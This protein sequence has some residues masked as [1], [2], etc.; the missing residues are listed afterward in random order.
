MNIPIKPQDAPWT[1]DQWKAI[2]ARG[3]DILVA[4][5][6]GS[7]KT[8][9]LVERIIQKILDEKD[10][11]NVNELLVA[12]FTNASAAEMRQRI[13][14]ALEKE[15]A[16]NPSSRHLRKQLNLLN[17]AQISTLHSFCLNVVKKYYYAIDI[18]P[19]FRIADETEALLLRDETLEELLEEEYGKENNEDF[20]RVVDIFTRDRSDS[21][22]EDLIS[23][24]YNFSRSHPEPEVWLDDLVEMYDATKVEKVDD[25]AFIGPLLYDIQ[26]KLEEAKRLFSEALEMTRLPGGPY[27]RAENFLQDIALVDQLLKAKD[28]SFQALYEAFQS[29]SFSTAKQAKGEDVDKEL[30]EQSLKLRNAGKKIIQD[31]KDE[32]FSRKP[33][34]FLKDLLE[35]KKPVETL[36]R[37][38]KTFSERFSRVKKEKGLI[39]F[40]DLEHYALEILSKKDPVTNK[41][42]PTDIA[43]TYRRQFKEVFID[44]YQ[45]TNMVQE[46]ILQ[47]VKKPGEATGNLFMVGDVKQSIYRFRLAE[48]NLFIGK[49]A[50]FTKDGHNTGLR[51]DLSQ[52]F[53]SRKEVLD[54][55]NFIFKQLMATRVGEIEYDEEAELKKGA[56]YPEEEAYPAE[57]VVLYKEQ[58]EGEEGTFSESDPEEEEDLFSKEEL[59]LSALE[60]RYIASKIRELID[61]KKQVYNPKTKAYHDIQYKDIVILLRSFT[62]ADQLMEEL[63]AKD[64]PAYANLSTGYFEATEVSIM[65]ALLNIIDNPYQD[66]PLAAV[67]RSP[68]VGLEEEEMARI[69]I[70]SKKDSFYEAAKAFQRNK[71]TDPLEE[72]LANKL[73]GFFQKLDAWRDLAR[74]ISLSKLIWQLYLDTKFYDFVG[75]MPGGKQ[76]QANL[77]ALYDRARQYE[78]TS[79]QGLF[80]FLRFIE[81]MKD[82]GEDLGVARALAEHEDVVRIMTIHSS[83]GLEFPV[84]FIS[85]LGRKFNMMDLRKDYLFDKDYGFA[86]NYVN[87]ELQITYPSLF[88]MSLVRKKR[89]ELVAEEMRILYV[90]MTRAK[91]KLYLVG[92]TKNLK[93]SLEKWKKA[94]NVKGWLLRDYDRMNTDNYLDWIGSTLVRHIEGETLAEGAPNHAEEDILHHPSRWKI[95]LLPENEFQDKSDEDA[96]QKEDLMEH[97]KR[98]E[99]VPKSSPY[100]DRIIFQLQ[101]KYPNLSATKS[102][103]KQS[104]TELK[105]LREIR[106]EQSGSE[107]LKPFK[108][109]IADRPDF[110]KEKQMT[111]AEKGTAMHMVMQHVD[112]TKQPTLD[113]LRKQLKRME[114][115]EL[116]TKEEVAEIRIE[117]II[118][119]FETDIGKRMLKAKWL[120]RELPFS[121]SL[122]ASEVYPDWSGENEPIFIQ[123]IID[124]LFKDEDGLVL[125]DYKTDQVIGRFK[126]LEFGKEVLKKR[127]ETQI[128]LYARAVESILGAK[129]DGSFLYFFD[130]GLLLEIKR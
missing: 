106:D 16:K 64:I 112:L 87:P 19:S 122:S 82:R 71:H 126:D 65:V 127:Y 61:S 50:R 31:L 81:K 14:E 8:A 77:R 10:P 74:R 76:R 94:L 73:D 28:D 75:G 56:S 124:C 42:I 39:D 97:I 78:S 79:F 105:R 83:K 113:S 109:P 68:I 111:S 90:A 30:A 121:L 25:L 84:V 48:P 118:R 21:D 88:H 7:G 120:R 35:M 99:P 70:Y 49:Y 38:V 13:G 91:E 107:F 101:W 130:G 41:R 15:I 32:I 45:D 98:G 27:M 51:I 5:A 63:K 29:V 62:V 33:D 57:F 44:E 92:A 18:D 116:L 103:S 96:E 123:G 3:K 52:N 115:M 53:R 86:C 85:G 128:Q 36:V 4:A 54:A 95:Q 89:L 129:L 40:N 47:L 114:E 9:V 22:L 110:L 100:K 20:F 37:L 72:R 66:I 117:D 93:K 6:A 46:T 1:L 11:T 80:R 104:V 59:E 43:E 125:L 17:S 34:T 23:K 55:T 119:F 12:T 58:E 60:A 69:R 2:H 67:L 102:R 108:K 26:L 24:I